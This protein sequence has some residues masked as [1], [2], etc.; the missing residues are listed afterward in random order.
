MVD[1]VLGSNNENI[2]ADVLPSLDE[3]LNA[4][5]ALLP[6]LTSR[7]KKRASGDEGQ[8]GEASERPRPAK[9][10]RTE[11]VLFDITKWSET[12]IQILL[13]IEPDLISSAIQLKQQLEEDYHSVTQEY[14]SYVDSK[15]S[16]LFE[17]VTDDIAKE[18]V[19]SLINEIHSVIHNL[20]ESI[21]HVSALPER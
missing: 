11:Y 21:L 6:D 7:R 3:Y 18:Q 12:D 2:M 8:A 4:D 20:P 5:S 9:R 10:P 15:L 13:D 14:L 19:Y 17:Q 16:T 1:N